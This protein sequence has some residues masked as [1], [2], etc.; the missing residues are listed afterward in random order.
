MGSGRPQGLA[1]RV[2]AA[3][4][5][6]AIPDRMLPTKMAAHEHAQPGTG[7]AAGLLGELQRL[8]LGRH[9]IV[10]ADDAFILDAEDLIEIDAPEGHK[11]RGGIRG[12]ATEL[13]IEGG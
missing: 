5:P 6:A 12:R 10:A 4:A 2:I 1:G 3:E 13:L 7:A 11:R 8:P 9:D